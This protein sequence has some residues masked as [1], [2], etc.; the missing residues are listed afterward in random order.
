MT[1]EAKQ[2]EQEE[3]KSDRTSK[4]M[5]DMFKGLREFG[6]AAMEKAE[7]FGKIATEKAEELS[8]L[9]KIKLDLHQLKRSR[10]KALAKLGELVFSLSKAKLAKLTEQEAYVTLT[11]SV[12]ELDLEVKKKEAQVNDIT[13]EEEDTEVKK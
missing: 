7:E 13:S 1:D 2:P 6:S 11:K 4:R 3:P 9:G 5:N 8:K 12:K 10:T